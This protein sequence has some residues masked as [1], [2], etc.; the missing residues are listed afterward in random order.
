M[1]YSLSSIILQFLL[2]MGAVNGTIQSWYVEPRGLQDI[3][4]GQ[5]VS[6]LVM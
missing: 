4:D 5:R 6:L 3:T 2:A 1:C